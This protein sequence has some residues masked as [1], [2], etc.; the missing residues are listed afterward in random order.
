[1]AHTDLAPGVVEFDQAE[2]NVGAQRSSS[3]A[4]VVPCTAM[5][6]EQGFAYHFMCALPRVP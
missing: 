1:M 5:L 4:R 2:R 6:V 3:E